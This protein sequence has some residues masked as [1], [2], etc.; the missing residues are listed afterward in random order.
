MLFSD[1]LVESAG[2]YQASLSAFSSGS[3]TADG[4][5]ESCTFGANG[6]ASASCMLI[7]YDYPTDSGPLMTAT[8]QGF[9]ASKAPLVVLPTP[10][11]S[12]NAAM[13]ISQGSYEKRGLCVL[14]VCTV[15]IL[16]GA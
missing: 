13:S 2:G 16:V 8:V 6:G 7:D 5:Y 14:I 4:F 1:T 9:E 10:T 15:L 11:S 12:P 3:V